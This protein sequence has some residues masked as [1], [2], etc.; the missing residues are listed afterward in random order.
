MID[1]QA[2]HYGDLAA[3]TVGG[4]ASLTFWTDAAS[5]GT[6]F[7][8]FLGAVLSVIWLA[9]RVYDRWTYGPVHRRGGDDA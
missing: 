6:V 8:T 4:G 7:L 1:E 3:F 2:R 9:W 5:A